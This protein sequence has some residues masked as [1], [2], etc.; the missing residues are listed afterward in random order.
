MKRVRR[1]EGVVTS[2]DHLV[3]AIIIIAFLIGFFT[4]FTHRGAPLQILVVTIVTLLA[5]VIKVLSFGL[6]YTIIQIAYNTEY[7]SHTSVTSSPTA[8]VDHPRGA[9][10]IISGKIR[11]RLNT[12]NK[13]FNGKECWVEGLTDEQIKKIGLRGANERVKVKVD[14]QIIAVKLSTLVPYETT[15]E[16]STSL[17]TPEA[18]EVPEAP[19][20]VSSD[21]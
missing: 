18:P 5:Y 1:F 8:S 13:D 7:L 16:A 9:N 11:C 10:S 21:T 17:E 4:A 3:L 12:T 14:D 15:N 6:I 2:L 20:K 19:V